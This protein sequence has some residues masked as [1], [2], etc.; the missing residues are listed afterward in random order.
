MK[1]N[2]VENEI[3]PKDLIEKY[4]FTEE[5]LELIKDAQALVETADMLPDDP[6]KFM[7]KLE[8]AI[9]NDFDAGWK[10]LAEIA[11]KDPKFMS[12][13]VA[14]NE[15]SNSV[16]EEQPPVIEKLSTEQVK[17][18]EADEIV[19]DVMTQLKGTKK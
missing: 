4:N 11:K 10:A 5:E 18:Q 15:I 1:K 3:L 8:K 13:I 17:E 2:N 6:D 19:S 7:N 14:L 16:V 9:P 12:Q